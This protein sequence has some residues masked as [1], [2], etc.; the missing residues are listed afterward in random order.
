MKHLWF[1][2]VLGLVGG[3]ATRAAAPV[4]PLRWGAHL[5]RLDKAWYASP[6]ARAAADTVLRY[7]SQPGAWPKN[8]DL[9]V[10][11]TP[12]SL[13][14][15]EKEGKANTIDNGATTLPIR[16]LARLTEA[17][18]EARYR[19]AVLRGVDY[20]LASQYPNGGFPQFFPLR[21]GYYSH[22]TYNDGAM[23]L[24][25]ELLRDVAES[26][27]SFGF[28]DAARRTRAAE[29]V[30]RGI[31]CI[32]RTQVRHAGRLT[33]W[34]AQ[35]DERTLAPAWARKYEPPSLSGSESVGVVRFLMAIERPTPG[36]VAAVEGAVAWFRAVPIRG[37]RVESVPVA[38]G[39]PDRRLVADPAAPPL[40]AR[41]YDLE[42]NRPLYMDRD[43]KPLSDFSQV[44]Y[45]RRS[46]YG[47]H[48]DWP[49]SLLARDHPA[50]CARLG[51]TA[52][53]AP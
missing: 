26:R 31:D 14:A 35:H 25:L 9:L 41:F 18:G 19:D 39:K 16:F 12:A 8:T 32:L 46:G 24:A 5:L 48:G 50:W 13:A 30:A 40:W 27:A 29:A 34:C 7:Q 11:P 37:Q 20:L 23:I 47:Y 45:E 4:E 2:L 1:A 49:A 17:T 51:R 15:L 42:T 33:A 36:I 3:A 10:P 52:T 43:S 28:V 38:G 21:Q 44:S 6:A 53:P 22:I